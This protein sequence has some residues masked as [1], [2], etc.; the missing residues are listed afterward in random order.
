MHLIALFAVNRETAEQ[1]LECVLNDA[2]SISV[3]EYMQFAFENCDGD[4][5]CDV[6]GPNQCRC[7]TRA[8]D[9]CG[10]KRF[11]RAV[12]RCGDER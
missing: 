12:R 5:T 9:R 8:V 1:W 4:D 6:N 11:T 7:R 2:A 10:W 3:E